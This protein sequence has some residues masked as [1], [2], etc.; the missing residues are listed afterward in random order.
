MRRQTPQLRVEQHHQLGPRL[1]IADIK[2]THEGGYI[3]WLIHKSLERGQLNQ[4]DIDRHRTLRSHEVW[5]TEKKKYK[6]GGIRLEHAKI[7]NSPQRS[8]SLKA[9]SIYQV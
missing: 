7:P 4:R 9:D 1:S 5:D 8:H 3:D 2:L 6:R